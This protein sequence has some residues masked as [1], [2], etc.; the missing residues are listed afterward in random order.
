MNN[1]KYCNTTEQN[2]PIIENS[3]CYKN[4]SLLIG[5]SKKDAVV[6]ITYISAIQQNYR[7]N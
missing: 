3:Q 6:N 7:S 1:N 4:I 5:I 2:E